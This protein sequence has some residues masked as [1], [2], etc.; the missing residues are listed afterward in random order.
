MKHVDVI[1]SEWMVSRLER[2]SPTT[3]ADLSGIHAPLRVHV[4]L[5]V[6]V[7]SLPMSE[8]PLLLTIAVL[9]TA[10]SPPPD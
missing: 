3:P 4:G 8:C 2:S 7:S 6:G 5:S 9:E 1:I 10:S